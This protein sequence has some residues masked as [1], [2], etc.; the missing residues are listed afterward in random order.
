MKSISKVIIIYGNTGT[1]K[2]SQ[3]E[4]LARYLYEKTGKP[5][6]LISAEASSF[7]IFQPLVEVGIVEPLYITGH[8]DPLTLMRWVICDGMWPVTVNGKWQ[9]GKTAPNSVSAYFIEGLSSFSESILEDQCTKQRKLSMDVVGAFEEGCNCD[10]EKRNDKHPV[11][12]RLEHTKECRVQKFS[13]AGRSHYGFAQNVLIQLLNNC[14]SLPAEYVV[15]SAH[16]ALGE[17]KD[18]RKPIRG[19]GIGGSAKT[20]SVQKYCGTLIHCEMYTRPG[21]ALT[22]EQCTA[23]LQPTTEA[24]VRMWYKSHPDKD[25]ANV[26]YKAKTTVPSMELAKLEAKYPGGFFVPGREHGLDE[27]VRAQEE[28][29]AGKTEDLEGWKVKVDEKFKEEK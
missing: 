29:L 26:E 13:H 6:R 14:P 7:Q 23:G 20:D 15:W 12:G 21:P 18:T 17:E 22:A 19:P 24:K 8:K 28:I 27:F 2:T 3:L 25:F 5:G 16:E 10:A 4:K 9:W 11:T 1:Y